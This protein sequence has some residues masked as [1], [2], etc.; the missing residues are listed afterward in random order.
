[1]EQTHAGRVALVTGASRGIG[2]A[3]AAQLV[4]RGARVF[5]TGRDKDA[6][7]ALADELNDSEIRFVFAHGDLADVEFCESLPWQ[8]KDDLGALDILI[9]NAGINEVARIEDLS[10]ESWERLLRVNLTAP[11]LLT[12]AAWPHLRDSSHAVIV[13][14]SSVSAM[15]RILSA[16]LSQLATNTA[17]S[18]KIR[19][20]R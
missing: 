6:L 13:N 10:L 15:V 8:C 7:A 11:F 3:V 2:R 5:G 17:M 20:L 18:S 14:V 1:M 4:A 12:K 19:P 16:L 9:N